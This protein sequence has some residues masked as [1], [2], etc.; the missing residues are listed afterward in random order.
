MLPLLGIA[1]NLVPT[2]AQ[3]IGGDKAGNVATQ[4][5]DVAKQVLGTSEPDAVSKAIATDPNLALQFKLAIANIEDKERQR[6]H[7]ELL[8]RMA[9]TQSAR[10]QTVKLA[11]MG[12]PLAW[13]AAVVSFIVTAAFAVVS[14]L[15]FNEAIPQQNREMA[16]YLVGQLSG[17]VG[18]CV[19][20]WVG[21]NA[22]S[23]AKDHTIK[24][25]ATS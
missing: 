10:D 3:W 24:K 1:L 13:G 25:L 4:V 17:F 14:W 5:A 6:S 9:D 18:T 12:S 23:A 11:Q 19:A 16:L 20:Y 21:S 8:A 15:V 7:D 22:Q 2:L